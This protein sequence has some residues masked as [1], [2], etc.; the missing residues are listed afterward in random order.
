MRLDHLLPLKW[1]SLIREDEIT[2]GEVQVR[3]I[4]WHRL[5][6]V[7]VRDRIYVFEGSCPHAGRS[8]QGGAVTSQGIIECPWHGLRL[9]LGCQPGPASAVP[10]TQLAFRVRNGIIAIDRSALRRKSRSR[11]GQ[12]TRSDD[13]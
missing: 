7:R 3:T 12:A 1:R 10:V 4:L 13:R 9:W 8:L 6:V 2:P 5:G 11:L